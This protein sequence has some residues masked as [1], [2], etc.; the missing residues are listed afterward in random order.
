MFIDDIPQG[1]K[2]RVEQVRESRAQTLG[3]RILGCMEFCNLCL[4]ELDFPKTLHIH[5]H[6]RYEGGA[7]YTEGCGQTCGICNTSPN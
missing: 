6:K 5:H 2:E 3:Q 7:T 1:V 4:R